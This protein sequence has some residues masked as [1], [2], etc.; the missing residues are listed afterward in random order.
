MSP[1]RPTDTIAAVATPPGVGG[2]GIIRVAG[3][4]VPDIAR[5]VCGVLPAPRHAQHTRFL[6][7]HQQPIDVGLVLYFPAPHSFTGDEILELHGHGG[8][9]V[10]DL[11]MRRV[12]ALGARPARPGEFSE[13]AFLNG[14]LDLVQAE[15]V[16][17]LIESASA[18]AARAALN[19]LQGAFSRR[20]Q[21]LVEDLIHLRLQIE[22]ALDFPEEEIDFLADQT[23]LDQCKQLRNGLLALLADSRQ[24]Q[25]LHD[26]MTV[27]LAGRPNAGKSSL[28]NLLAAQDSAIVSDIPGTTRDVLR[29]RIQIDGLPLHVIDTAGLRIAGDALESEG[30]RR[31]RAAMARADR[32]L[33]VIDDLQDTPESVRFVISELPPAQPLTV[34]RNKIDLSGR[35]AGYTEKGESGYPEIALS[36]RTGFGLEALHAHLKVCMGYQSAGEGMFSARRRHLEALERA[37]EHVEQAGI[38]LGHRRGELAAEQLRQVQQ[39][40][41]EITGEFTSDDLLGRIFTSFCIGK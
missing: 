25:L 15:A 30:V 1:P 16:A 19:S 6:D 11:L 10:L 7:A 28:L 2:I 13:R 21:A 41:G 24:G 9:V 38:E 36:A 18:E 34:V 37:R 33:L 5:A 35:V 8:P 39:A 12:T 3:P 20:V 22:A 26:G 40:L 31:A 29:E 14:K 23:L 17:D 4:A 32:I 27:V